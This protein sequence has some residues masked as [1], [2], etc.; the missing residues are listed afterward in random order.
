MLG[1]G[2]SGLTFTQPLCSTKKVSLL[3]KE[4]AEVTRGRSDFRIQNS[5]GRR[6]A[7]ET[8]YSN[9]DTGSIYHD[10]ALVALLI[11]MLGRCVS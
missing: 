8:V 7:S 9:L 2:E 1:G 10:A 3:N 5:M 11:T 4:M 6:S